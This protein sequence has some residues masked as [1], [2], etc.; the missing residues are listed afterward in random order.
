LEG[1]EHQAKEMLVDFTLLMLGQHLD[2]QVVEVV[3]E[4]ELLVLMA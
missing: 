3:V 2:T 1:K 4:P